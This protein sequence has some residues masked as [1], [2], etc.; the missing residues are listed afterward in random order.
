MARY[1]I[2][3]EDKLRLSRILGSYKSATEVQSDCVVRLSRILG[4][5]E[6][7]ATDVLNSAETTQHLLDL[8]GVEVV[9]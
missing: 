2:T 7:V 1:Q 5:D 9:G 8:V 6:H 3:I 4:T